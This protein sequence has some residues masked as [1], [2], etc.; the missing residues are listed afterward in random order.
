MVFAVKS[1]LFVLELVLLELTALSI[2]LSLST[3][4]PHFAT[5]LT[6]MN[7]ARPIVVFFLLVFL[8]A[9]PAS[10]KSSRDEAFALD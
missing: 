9:V 8:V 6:P 3:A 7:L 4:P 1:F 2:L 10:L 5:P